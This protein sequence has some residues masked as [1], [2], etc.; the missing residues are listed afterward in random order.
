MEVAEHQAAALNNADIK[1][2]VRAP[3][4]QL[5]VFFIL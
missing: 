3:L 2:T 5:L 4:L 1:I